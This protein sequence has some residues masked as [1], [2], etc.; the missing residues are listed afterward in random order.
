MGK[1]R[2]AGTCLFCLYLPYFFL[3]AH[4]PFH[5]GWETLQ[6]AWEM[7]YSHTCKCRQNTK[8]T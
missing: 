3:Q 1:R 8:N 2:S 7:V 6:V 4:P 5:F